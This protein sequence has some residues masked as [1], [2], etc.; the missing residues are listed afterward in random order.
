MLNSY[1]EGERLSF[2]AE[3][4]GARL[5]VFRRR[6]PNFNQIREL[7]STHE[8]NSS[9]ECPS[10]LHQENKAACRMALSQI[11]RKCTLVSA[12]LIAGIGSHPGAR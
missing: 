9:A 3:F 4:T 7:E 10:I 5:L 1:P 8:W 2:A 12:K 11:N 6:D